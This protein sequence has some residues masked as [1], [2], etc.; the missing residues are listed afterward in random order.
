MRTVTAD[1]VE[2]RKHC[3]TLIAAYQAPQSCELVDAL[4]LAPAD[5][6]LK[7]ELRK[8]YWAGMDRQIH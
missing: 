3:E 4:P 2:I 5:K 6:V 1:A 7:H 8:R